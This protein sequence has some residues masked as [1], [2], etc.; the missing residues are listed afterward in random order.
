M[1]V[2][3]EVLIEWPAKEKSFNIWSSP[4]F[5]ENVKRRLFVGRQLLWAIISYGTSISTW[6]VWESKS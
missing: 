3:A 1:N 6:K 2:N 5:G 4:K